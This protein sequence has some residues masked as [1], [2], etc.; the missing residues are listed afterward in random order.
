MLETDEAR[1]ALRLQLYGALCWVTREEDDKL[2]QNGFR[3]TRPNG[4]YE[5]Y[6]QVGIEVNHFHRNTKNLHFFNGKVLPVQQ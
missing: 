6:K 4:W 2:N 5:C 1:W 3:H